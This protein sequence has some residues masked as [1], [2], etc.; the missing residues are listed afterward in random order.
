MAEPKTKK[1]MAS[2][3]AFIESLESE[4][5]RKEG[6]EL[7]KIFNE[8]TGVRPAMWGPSII[9]YGTYHY[10]SERST[11]EGDWPLVGF[12][13]R[14]SALT[15]YLASDF[16]KYDALMKKLGKYKKSV[17]CT[18]VNK[19]EDINIPTLKAL[20]KE[21]LTYMKKHYPSARLV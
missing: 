10:K 6:K 4:R 8:V 5:R 3:T 9:G 17:A 2:V 18:Y 16:E 21:S 20:I 19:L 11:Q 12:S 14:K 15:L 1:T 7:V 13:P